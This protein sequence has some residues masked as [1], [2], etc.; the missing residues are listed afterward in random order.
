[1]SYGS[2][3]FAR[4]FELINKTNQ[5]NTT[6]RRWSADAIKA[7]MDAGM[8]LDAFE[9]RDRLTSYGL[10]GVCLRSDRNIDQFVM[11]C[12]V[13]GLDVEM[14]ALATILSTIPKDEAVKAT[15]VETPSNLL[16]RD[17]WA[18]CGFTVAGDEWRLDPH[19]RPAAPAHIQVTSAS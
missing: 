5:F 4:A 13:N 15:F 19:R 11:S 9:V 12:R 6:G 1:V 3:R 14:A 2:A 7:A 18:R 16:C 17:L 10:V 8:T